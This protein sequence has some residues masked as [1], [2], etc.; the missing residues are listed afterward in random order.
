LAS[1]RRGALH[2][3]ADSWHISSDELTW[4]FKLRPGLKF[5]NGDPISA[6]AF[7]RSLTRMA[8]L[9]KQRKSEE[10]FFSFVKDADK[11]SSPSARFA[12]IQADPNDNLVIELK[13]PNPKLLQALSFGLFALIHPDLYDANTGAW[14][15]PHQ[16]ISSG[17]Y[18]IT[19]WQGESLRM[20]HR[21]DFTWQHA[22]A[23][24]FQKVVVRWDSKAQSEADFIPDV[25]TRIPLM[26]RKDLSFRSSVEKTGIYYACIYTW[27]SHPF[28]KVARNRRILRDLFYHELASEPLIVRSFLP[29]TFDGISP[30]PLRSEDSIRLDAPLH[31]KIHTQNQDLDQGALE[32]KLFARA[33]EKAIRRLG[34]QATFEHVS[35]LSTQAYMDLGKPGHGQRSV[36]IGP[37]GTGL[38]HE[39]IDT[40][41][42]FMVLSQEGIRL[43]DPTGK[44]AA[45]VRKPKVD[46]ADFNRQLWEDA[47][48]W[49]LGHVTSGV[50]ITNFVDVH[51][52][53]L[54]FLSV[55]F[56]LVGRR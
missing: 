32:T 13:Q 6:E 45:I 4:T 48:V 56:A 51:L 53:D 30:F 27:E 33:I 8:F 36:D 37:R 35:N 19:Q 7:R 3:L 31:F 16:T 26:Q 15:D 40:T 28:F 52:H 11:V 2:F 12:G 54:S 39:N 46:L 55:N 47:V 44:L 20:E 14:K 5:G 41:V 9:L 1:I 25:A 21:K 34:A 18:S 49:P 50:W 17:P 23:K 42:R 43:P 29:L 24:P 38:D 22:H 10:H